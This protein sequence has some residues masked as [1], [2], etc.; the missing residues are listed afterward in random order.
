MRLSRHLAAAAAAVAGAALL[1]PSIASAQS[2]EPVS[3]R[4]KGIAGGALLGAEA[5]M[6]V[7]AA[8]SVQPTWA[9]VAGGIAGAV[10][11]GVGGYFLEDS[12]DP[13]VSLYLL[14]GGMALMIPTTVAV[15]ATTTYKPP[16]DYT[17]D[18]PPADEPVAEPPEASEPSA[19]PA[20]TTPSPTSRRSTPRKLVLPPPS[21]LAVRDGGLLLSVPA[22]EVRDL[23]SR[24]EVAQLGVRQGTEVR[25]PV[26][27]VTF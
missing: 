22:V 9:Y 12:A 7:E 11:G 5:V 8:F 14:A 24:R 4:G 3:A 15:L 21:L 10:G 23:Y 27:D 18:K 1:L 16:A 26:L 2:E 19:A 13:K 6:L 20:E 17:E 25:V